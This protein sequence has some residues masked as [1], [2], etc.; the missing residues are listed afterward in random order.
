MI[1]HGIETLELSLNFNRGNVLI[2]SGE[3]RFGALGIINDD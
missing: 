2:S 1:I 3:K